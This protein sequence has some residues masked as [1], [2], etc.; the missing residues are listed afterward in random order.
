MDLD[1]YKDYFSLSPVTNGCGKIMPQT[2]DINSLIFDLNDCND[3]N[4]AYYQVK[5]YESFED[6]ENFLR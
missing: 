3:T 6:F 1:A 4:F 2:K 5:S